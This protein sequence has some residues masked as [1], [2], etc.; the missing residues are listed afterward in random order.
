MTDK[1]KKILKNLV[2]QEK[3]SDFKQ[4]VNSKDTILYALGIGY[5]EDP[6]N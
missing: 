3:I 4:S 6:L 1:P 2:L 5:S